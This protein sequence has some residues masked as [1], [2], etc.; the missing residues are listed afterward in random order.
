MSNT[1]NWNNFLIR[2]DYFIKMARIGFILQFLEGIISITK[3]GLKIKPHGKE[4]KLEYGKLIKTAIEKK[5]FSRRI[6]PVLNNSLK[7]FLH[8]LIVRQKHHKNN[9]DLYS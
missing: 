2:A 9:A 5:I 7:V 1:E 6:E 3:Y 8:G 4:W